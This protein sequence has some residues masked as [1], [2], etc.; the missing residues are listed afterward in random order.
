MSLCATDLCFIEQFYGN[1]DGGCEFTHGGWNGGLA[2]NKSR[3]EE[4]LRSLFA[5]LCRT[6]IR[7]ADVASYWGVNVVSCRC[8]TFAEP[9][10]KVKSQVREG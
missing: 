2:G 8:G 5:P 9:G 3:E 1:A 4:A 10:L 6:T 7:Y